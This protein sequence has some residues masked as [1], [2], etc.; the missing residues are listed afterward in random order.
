[1]LERSD[2]G[3]EE[4]DSQTERTAKL[5]AEQ[6]LQDT[7]DNLRKARRILSYISI[8]LSQMVKEQF[9]Q[10]EL[11]KESSNLRFLRFHSR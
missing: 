1:L 4:D 3:E 9:H 10:K 2:S 5:I 8:C 11:Q 7:G 6:E